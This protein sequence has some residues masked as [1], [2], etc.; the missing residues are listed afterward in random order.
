[1]SNLSNEE[2]LKRIKK[3]TT[4]K[5]KKIKKVTKKV[6]KVKKVKLVLTKKPKKTKKPREVVFKKLIEAIPTTQYIHPPPPPIS[7]VPIQ[8]PQP[9]PY[10][11][12]G[13][14]PPV[15]PSPNVFQ[16]FQERQK[17]DAIEFQLN[18]LKNQLQPD[19]DIKTS[20]LK[21]VET[22]SIGLMTDTNSTISSS[23]Q[24]AKPKYK[25]FET[26]TDDLQI[27]VGLPYDPMVFSKT[28][29]KQLS[30]RPPAKLLGEVSH[31]VQAPK[32]PKP[33]ETPE[34]EGRFI[35]RKHRKL[36]P[37]T[38]E[39]VTMLRPDE[40]E[41]PQLV[42]SETQNEELNN[43]INDKYE[44]L[45][46]AAIY[47]VFFAPKHIK[48]SSDVKRYVDNLFA[49][50]GDKIKLSDYKATLDDNRNVI[51]LID[52]NTGID[53][54]NNFIENSYRAMTELLNSSGREAYKINKLIKNTAIKTYPR[55]IISHL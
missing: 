46:R 20:N 17:L 43:Y 2:T 24:T 45:F 7:R 14:Y 8:Y 27:P 37:A 21:P 44:E 47:N 1:M 28:E 13:S 41:R 19:K 32:Q 35:R 30:G 4:K 18:A 29:P 11:S 52:I 26:Q 48:I 16:T 25:T 34:P 38:V 33:P 53:M 6:K 40:I 12:L 49:T 23:A 39:K 55:E 5:T 10:R 51:S 31:T 9:P 50:T 42:A 3:L 54:L 15:Q 22:K 36:R